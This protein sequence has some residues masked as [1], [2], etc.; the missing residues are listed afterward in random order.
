MRSVVSGLFTVVAMVCMIVAVPSVWLTQRVVSTDGFV[1][2]ASEAA[3]TSEV[4]DYFSQKV[5]DS[6]E[7][8]SGS[9]LASNVALPLAQS[10][11]RTDAFVRDFAEV[12]RQQHDWLF[13]Q[14]A[15]DAD[16]HLMELDITPMINDAIKQASI[17]VPVSFDRPILVTI[18]QRQITAGSMEDSGKLVTVAAWVSVIGAIVAALLALLLAVRRSTVLAWLGVGGVLA[19]VIGAL[20]AVATKSVVSDRLADTDPSARNTIEVVVGGIS[21]DLTQL[22]LLVGVGGLIVLAVGGVAR[23]VSGRRALA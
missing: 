6:I 3:K 21:D 17:P 16:L 15:P 12:A 14:P 5:A 11:S 9:K 8:A 19:G 22:S 2:S 7:Q 18:D 1:A 23:V 10:Y 4:Q 20:L 13:T